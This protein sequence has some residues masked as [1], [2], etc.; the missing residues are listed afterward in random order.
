MAGEQRQQAKTG[1]PPAEPTESDLA[2]GSQSCWNGTRT[3]SQ[4]R[5]NCWHRPGK[6]SGEKAGGSWGLRLHK[7]KFTAQSLTQKV[8]APWGRHGAG[9]HGSLAFCSHRQGKAVSFAGLIGL[10]RFPY[11]SLRGC[12]PAWLACHF[13]LLTAY[14]LCKRRRGEGRDSS[15]DSSCNDPVSICAAL[16]GDGSA[17]R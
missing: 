1:H 14:P 8:G 16:R 10:M 4:A 2:W 17:N 9:E 15:P 12:Q 11:S 13:P 3:K 7:I 5:S 6:E